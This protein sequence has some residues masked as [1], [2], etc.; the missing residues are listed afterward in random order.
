MKKLYQKIRHI[1][2]WSD[3]LIDSCYV[4]VNTNAMIGIEIMV[5]LGRLRHTWEYLMLAKCSLI[6]PAAMEKLM[7]FPTKIHS[8]SHDIHLS[9]PCC[10]TEQ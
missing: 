3:N 7:P 10:L 8:Y 5:T 2:N 9:P 6:A 1:C 4:A